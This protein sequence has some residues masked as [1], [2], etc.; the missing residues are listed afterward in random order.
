MLSYSHT[1]QVAPPQ[2]RPSSHEVP[3]DRTP[4]V[5]L[6]SNDTPRGVRS[7]VRAG[8]VLCVVW[9]SYATLKETSI[10]A[11]T[12]A[13]LDESY[14]TDL[15]HYVGVITAML[16]PLCVAVGAVVFVSGAIRLITRGADVHERARGKKNMVWGTVGLCLAVSVWGVVALLTNLLGIDTMVRP[17][18]PN[19]PALLR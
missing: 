19:T 18:V 16:V 15:V 2:D 7:I 4:F 5:L 17:S 3:C 12:S 9:G 11:T 8:I 13:I 10:A 1:V 6:D 14:A